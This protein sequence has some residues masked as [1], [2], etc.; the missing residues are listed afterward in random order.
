[1]STYKRIQISAEDSPSAV[2]M[3][4][5]QSELGALEFV[6]P[7]GARLFSE[8]VNLDL[9]KTF[10]SKAGKTIRIITNDTQGLEM[11][12]YLG[13]DAQ[14]G[15]GSEDNSETQTDA[16]APNEALAKYAITDLEAPI[17]PIT[18]P[19]NEPDELSESPKSKREAAPERGI[20]IRKT[21]ARRMPL[22]TA[23]TA[24]PTEQTPEDIKS[25]LTSIARKSVA[26]AIDEDDEIGTRKAPGSKWHFGFGRSKKTEAPR[27]YTEEPT[28]RSRIS[29]ERELDVFL[30]TKPTAQSIKAANQPVGHGG[31]I[32]KIAIVVLILGVV[33]WGYWYLP[34]ATV[35]VFSKRQEVEFDLNV[36][37]DK[38]ISKVAIPDRKIPGQIIFVEKTTEHAVPTTGEETVN[39][40]AHAMITVYNKQFA[41][42]SM[43]PSRFEFSDGKI[44]WSQKSITIPAAKQGG[45]Q[46]TP[47]SL[48]VEVLADK[49]GEAYNVS[50]SK[51]APCAFTVPAWKGTVKFDQVYGTGVE[52]FVGGLVGVSKTVTQ[53]DI[54]DA[55]AGLSTEIKDQA[56][57]EL[58]EKVPSNFELVEES[59]Q[60]ELSDIKLSHKLKD[61]TNEI[62]ASATAT[63]RGMLISPSDLKAII[64]ETVKAEVGDQKVAHEDTIITKVNTTR[65][66]IEQ[67]TMELSVN[68]REEVGWKFDEQTLI[69]QL[70]GKSGEEVRTLFSQMDRVQEAQMRLWP[71][72]VQSVPK[73][74]NR[75][76]LTIE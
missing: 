27:P 50:C 20:D 65:V 3:H 51:E 30:H 11:A 36:I 54:D 5:E 67:G 75:I 60:T 46:V 68:A 31:Q 39:S 48:D 42:Q 29:K 19:A 23:P 9:L 56:L 45:N 52:H 43:I 18:G 2:I 37:A 14:E 10:A 4:L 7:E 64:H 1:M 69:R 62:T 74:T 71:F 44:F 63:A 59:V 8:S 49:A 38:N 55:R 73:S 21:K 17:I 35:K 70:A 16:D 61:P 34:K 25:E 40:K 22:Y 15:D 26:S 53:K 32:V 12:R 41:A 13:I 6:V 76:T 28:D 58:R 57:K 72:W 24:Q 47:G 33:G 66:D